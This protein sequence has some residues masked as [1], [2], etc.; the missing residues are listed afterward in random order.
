MAFTCKNETN[1]KLQ[2]RIQACRDAGMQVK[3]NFAEGTVVVTM[4][5][6]IVLR[7]KRASIS[8]WDVEY[9]DEFWSEEQR[10]PQE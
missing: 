4:E 9:N 10:E 6:E 3:R 2:K 7:G 8:S 1:D 5:E